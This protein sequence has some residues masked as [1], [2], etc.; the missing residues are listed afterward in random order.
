MYHDKWRM[1]RN[2]LGALGLGG[3]SKNNGMVGL[4]EWSAW[5]WEEQSLTL[6]AVMI[7]GEEKYLGRKTW[8]NRPNVFL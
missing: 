8:V 3:E 5:R 2:M 1:F 7:Q 6:Q 4:G